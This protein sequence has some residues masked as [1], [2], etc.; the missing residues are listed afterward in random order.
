MQIYKL[1]DR[2]NIRGG[3]MIIIKNGNVFCPDGVFRKK[4]VLIGEKSIIAVEDVIAGNSADT[5][6]ACGLYVMP[7]LIDIHTHGA[8]GH[9]MMGSGYD[10]LSSMSMFYAS[11]GVTSFLGTTMTSPVVKVT[12]AIENMRL[13][14]K[15]GL[16][17]ARMIGIHLEGPFINRKFKGAHPEEYI[18]HPSIEL[19]ERFIEKSEGNIRMV[20]LAPEMEGTGAIIE[21]F[22]KRNLVFSAGHSGLNYSEALKAFN[23]G[24]THITHLFNGMSGLHHREPG[25]VGAALDNDDIS[26][27]LIADG[28]HVHPSVIRMAVR[29]KTS[30][31]AVLIT[32]S[33]MAA[34][35]ADGEYVLGDQKIIL[36]NREAR[37]ENGALAGSVLTM[38]DALKNMFFN[39]GIPL[40]DAVKMATATPA[41]IIRIDDKKGTVL[42]GKDADIVLADENLNVKMTMVEGKVVYTS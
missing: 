15:E 6:D 41:R 2:F 35:L 20:T 40:E 25:L 19:L 10:K 13:A 14:I 34:G 16:P 37:L 24:V 38:I 17:G 39:F 21:Y 18:I 8:Y 7:G 42:P 12:E 27:E 28:I 23:S 32:D 11:K 1:A 26:V 22:K 33:N 5:L 9:D 31:S 29:I 3:K 4:D 36:R 30:R